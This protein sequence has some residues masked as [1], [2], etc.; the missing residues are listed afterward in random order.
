MTV[1]VELLERTL[2]TI[3]ANPEHWNQVSWHCNTSHCF[4]GFTELLYFGLPINSYDRN[5]RKDN[6]IHCGQ[7]GSMGSYWNTSDNA[8]KALALNEDDAMQL[9]DGGNTLA[10]L[11]SMVEHLVEFGNLV[12]YNND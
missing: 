4:A 1:N 9:F 6:R 7:V 2:A 12:D 8:I 5:L 11:E 10:D 3:K